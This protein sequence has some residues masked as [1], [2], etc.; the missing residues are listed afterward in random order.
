MGEQIQALLI[1]VLSNTELWEVAFTFGTL[2]LAKFSH[3]ALMTNL[4]AKRQESWLNEVAVLA[5]EAVAATYNDIVRDAKEAGIFD[6]AT[7]QIARSE[8]K[9]KMLEIA[10]TKGSTAL[11]D[12][13]SEA[14]EVYIERAVNSLKN[15]AKGVV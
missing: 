6:S 11:K 2:A 8:A 13:A 9:A 14:F 15:D 10:Q 4:R 12:L 7:K 3:S 5:E 1:S